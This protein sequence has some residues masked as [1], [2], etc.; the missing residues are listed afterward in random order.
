MAEQNAQLAWVIIMKNSNC[1]QPMNA[2]ACWGFDCGNSRRHLG[3]DSEEAVRRIT[4]SRMLRK[5]REQQIREGG[6]IGCKG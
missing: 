3:R 1:Y 6:F 2:G 5:E 4:G